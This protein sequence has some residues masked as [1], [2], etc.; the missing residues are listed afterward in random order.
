MWQGLQNITD[1]KGKPSHGL[2]SDASLPDQL[3][4]FYTRFE[5][6]N[7]EPCMR[8]PVIPNDCLI[9]VSVANVSKTFNHV[10]IHKAEGPD[11]LP[12]HILRAYAD[13]LASMVFFVVVLDPLFLPSLDLAS[14]LQL[15]NEL[16]M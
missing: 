15:A 11:G 12:G 5:A 14:L 6:T 1:H 13:Q 7:P 10:N 16:W 2:P 9:T 8:A 3:N 4:V